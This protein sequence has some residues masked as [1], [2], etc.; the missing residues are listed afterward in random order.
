MK[1]LEREV[2]WLRRTN[3]TLNLASAFFAMRSSTSTQVL[4]DF[5]DRHRDTFGVEPI[6]KVLQIAHS[7]YLLHA[8][9]QRYPE[10]DCARAKR[11]QALIP[12]VQRVMLG[13]GSFMLQTRA[14]ST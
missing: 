12:E 5:I 10:L 13:S 4:I 7:C 11:D 14:G 3:E 9:H 2:K 6:Y 8:T 1:A